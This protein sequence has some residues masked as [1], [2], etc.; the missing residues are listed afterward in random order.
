MNLLLPLLLSSVGL[1]GLWRRADVYASLTRGAEDGFRVVLRI[2]PALVTLL[3][4][5]AMFRASG[6]MELLS[7][8]C[9]PLLDVLGIPPETA[10]LLLV[11]PISGSGALATVGELIRVHGVNSRVGRTA[12][13]MLGSTETTFYTVAVYFGAAGIR[14]TRHAI[15]AALAADVTG[16]VVAALTVRLF[17]PE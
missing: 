13:V 9:A 15:P 1:C 7:A 11:R 5:V 14:R 2:L 6:A 17:F 4:A 16:F 10:P 8:W 12:A 3:P